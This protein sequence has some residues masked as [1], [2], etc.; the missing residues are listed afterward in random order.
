MTSGRI[1][2]IWSALILNPPA[3]FKFKQATKHE[4]T[5]ERW[6]EALK[7]PLFSVLSAKQVQGHLKPATNNNN[8]NGGCFYPVGGILVPLTKLQF[9]SESSMTTDF[10]NELSFFVFKC[11]LRRINCFFLDLYLPLMLF[12]V[13]SCSRMQLR[14]HRDGNT[15]SVCCLK[16]AR[17]LSWCTAGQNGVVL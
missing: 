4:N 11:S 6:Q 7:K 9:L 3:A 13:L 8:N 16:D 5:T 10:K 1:T 14:K 17:G 12:V 15:S 2:N